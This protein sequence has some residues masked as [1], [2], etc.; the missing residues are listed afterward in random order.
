MVAHLRDAKVSLKT[1]RPTLAMAHFV[2]AIL[3][4]AFF[5]GHAHPLGG[6]S[7]E[8]PFERTFSQQ[9]TGSTLDFR[10]NMKRNP[11]FDH[12]P[13]TEKFIETIHNGNSDLFLTILGTINP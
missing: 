2:F 10:N 9:Q 11:L 7:F 8:E 12:F 1:L 13:H 5:K 6:K 4:S 3:S